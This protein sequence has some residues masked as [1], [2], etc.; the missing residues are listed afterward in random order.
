MNSINTEIVL[1]LNRSFFHFLRN[2]LKR[3]EKLSKLMDNCNKSEHN[4]TQNIAQNSFL[5][6]LIYSVT[7]SL[8]SKTINNYYI[9]IIIVI[10]K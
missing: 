10:N 3:K 4:I 1:C 6:A 2:L 7:F 5:D 8:K 9:H